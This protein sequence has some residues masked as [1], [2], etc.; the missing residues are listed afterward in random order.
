[1][2]KVRT[3]ITINKELLKKVRKN[4]LNL[5]AFV[6]IKLK[7]YFALIEGGVFGATFDSKKVLSSP[8]RIRTA[9][10]GSKGRND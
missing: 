3:N 6:D 2:M 10:V 7:E 8:E 5:S 9:V 1:M 4:D